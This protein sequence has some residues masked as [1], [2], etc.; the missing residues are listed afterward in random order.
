[1][2]EKNAFCD[3]EE[4]SKFGEFVTSYFGWLPISKQKDRAEEM[5]NMT[6]NNYKNNRSILTK[7]K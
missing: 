3:N 6:K 5:N 7:R 4:T 1:M 2:K